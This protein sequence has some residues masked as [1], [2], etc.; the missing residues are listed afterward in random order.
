[1]T[2][3]HLGTTLRR[4][5]QQRNFFWRWMHSSFKCLRLRC[6]LSCSSDVLLI[7]CF[8]CSS[9]VVKLAILLL[10]SSISFSPSSSWLLVS[11][12]YQTKS[13]QF[14]RFHPLMSGRPRNKLV[15]MNWSFICFFL[16]YILRSTS[17]YWATFYE[18]QVSHFIY[19]YKSNEAKISCCYSEFHQGWTGSLFIF[20]PIYASL[21]FYV[22][23]NVLRTS[24]YTLYICIYIYIKVT[25]QRSAVATRSFTRDEL[26][27]Y[28]FFLPYMLRS[29]SMYWAMFYEHQVTHFIYVYIYIYKSNKAKV[30]CC[31]SEFHQGW[32]GSLFIFS[33][34]H[35]SLYFYVLSNVL[36]TSSFTLYIWI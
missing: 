17:M 4:L 29:T 13:R 21:Y 25:R 10:F 5:S 15:G 33:P 36:R 31:Y 2:W 23:S 1:M 19:E 34:I 28:L 27:V 24:S 3:I 11:K 6:S 32:T 22:L 7:S 9:S 20:S 12:K 35:A 18:H 26:V 8:N 30:S 14:R 16:P